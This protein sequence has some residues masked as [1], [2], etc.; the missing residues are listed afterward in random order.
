MSKFLSLCFR[1]LKLF[2]S[3][4]RLFHACKVIGLKFSRGNSLLKCRINDTKLKGQ[5]NICHIN[6]RKINIV[7]KEMKRKVCCWEGI[8]FTIQR[9]YK[10]LDDRSVQ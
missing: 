8:D 6:I 5:N 1:W 9:V 4:S 7:V 10:R 3:I 2:A